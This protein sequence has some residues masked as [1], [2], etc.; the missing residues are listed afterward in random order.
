MS[1]MSDISCMRIMRHERH[2]LDE[3]H[4]KLLVKSARL[5]LM[6]FVLAR[7]GFMVVMAADT[8]AGGFGLSSFVK[9]ACR[10]HSWFVACHDLV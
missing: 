5:V 8:R 10:E 3:Y 4:E 7:A 2:E 9:R 1:G 6:V